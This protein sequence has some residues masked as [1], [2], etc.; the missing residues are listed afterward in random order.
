LNNHQKS[1]NS[2]FAYLAKPKAC[3]GETFAERGINIK[4]KLPGSGRAVL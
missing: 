3:K 1:G 2:C 4:A